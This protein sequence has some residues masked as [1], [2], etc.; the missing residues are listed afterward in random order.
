MGSMLMLAKF[1]SQSSL[2]GQVVAYFSSSFFFQFWLQF[3]DENPLDQILEKG[4]EQTEWFRMVN[5]A[6]SVLHFVLVSCAIFYNLL[7][8]LINV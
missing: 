5:M 6:G 2:H 4:G 1:K 8:N 7:A 3:E